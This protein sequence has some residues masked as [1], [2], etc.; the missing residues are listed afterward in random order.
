MNKILFL[1]IVL[2]INQISNAQITGTWKLLSVQQPQNNSKINFYSNFPILKFDSSNKLKVYESGALHKEF[3]NA[4]A[5]SYHEKFSIEYLNKYLIIKNHRNEILFKGTYKIGKN[6]QILTLTDTNLLTYKLHKTKLPK[7][8]LKDS[9]KDSTV[10]FRLL[11]KRQNPHE[12]QLIYLSKNNR[13]KLVLINGSIGINYFDNNNFY[14]ISA[15]P[16][17]IDSA[18]NTLVLFPLSISSSKILTCSN[19]SA[20]LFFPT[21]ELPIEQIEKIY[22]VSPKS[23]RQIITGSAIAY[24]GISSASVVAMFQFAEI[25]LNSCAGTSSNTDY[26][27]AYIF[28]AA[29]TGAGLLTLSSTNNHYYI[30]N[31]KKPNKDW[32]LEYRKFNNTKK[33]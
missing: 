25:L 18:S 10:V 15:F 3:A 7:T 12:L 9:S 11:K 14:D 19:V 30:S 8:I 23:R 28:S 4:K 24:T 6:K 32:H 33:N 1:T 5:L 2:I 31:D 16:L 27:P 17:Y 21:I 13:N 26:T 29:L 20:S 22:Y